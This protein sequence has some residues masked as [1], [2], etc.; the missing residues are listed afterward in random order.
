MLLPRL[1]PTKLMEMAFCQ[2]YAAKY[3]SSRRPW[4]NFIVSVAAV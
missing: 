3:A 2:G 4:W 1:F